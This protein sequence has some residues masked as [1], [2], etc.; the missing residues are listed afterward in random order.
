MGG[1][2]WYVGSR[3]DLKND[4]GSQ[5]GFFLFMNKNPGKAVKVHY[6]LEVAFPL[7]S[8]MHSEQFTKVF[9]HEGTGRGAYLTSDK[10]L[11]GINAA[12][13]V[14]ITFKGYIAS[15]KDDPQAKK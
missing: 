10:Y 9:D 13:S 12:D 6:T 3:L 8:L 5:F 7:R 1:F 4:G 15:V 2:N 11:K 14:I